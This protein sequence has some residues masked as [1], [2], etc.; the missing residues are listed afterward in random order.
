MLDELA[1]GYKPQALQ[2][3][4]IVLTGDD[5][6]NMR[7]EWDLKD[8]T[9]SSMGI[10]HLKCNRKLT[11]LLSLLMWLWLYWVLLGVLGRECTGQT[12]VEQDMRWE[13][14]GNHKLPHGECSCCRTLHLVHSWT[15]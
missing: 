2:K 14:C 1:S 9:L 6:H 5:N 7:L 15:P 10:D 12:E 3:K 8:Y 4:D 13:E 11:A